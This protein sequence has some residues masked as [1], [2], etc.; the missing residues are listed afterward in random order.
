MIGTKQTPDITGEVQPLLDFLQQQVNDNTDVET[1]E[2]DSAIVAATAAIN[3]HSDVKAGE[4]TTHVN[5]KTTALTAHVTSKKAEL[6]AEALT[7]KDE[8]KAYIAAQ[9]AALNMSPIR[10]IQRGSAVLYNGNTVIANI[11]AVDMAKTTISIS[12]AI[13]AH[14]QSQGLNLS[15]GGYLMSSTQI[16]LLCANFSNN[17]EVPTTVYWEAVEYV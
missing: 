14:D 11:S 13:G 6:A 4:V 9:L 7:N 17:T 8:I 3:S 15:A 10:S 5:D 1:A 2:I 12:N 16:R